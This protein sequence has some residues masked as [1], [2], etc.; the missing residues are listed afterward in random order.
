M[1]HRL[2]LFDIDETMIKSDGTGRRAM[3]RA[4]RQVFGIA[5][6]TTSVA[7]SGKTDWQICREILQE[8]GLISGDLEFGLN[9]VFQVYPPMLAEE[10]RRSAGYRLH[11]GVKELIAALLSTRSAYLGLVTGNI[12]PGARLKLAPFDLN[13]FFPVGAFGSDSADRMDLPP[14]A[15]NRAAAHYRTDFSPEEVVVVGDSIADVRCAAGYGALS[16]AVASGKTPRADLAACRPHFLF[17]SLQDTQAVLDA[18]FST[19]TL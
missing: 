19:R 18:I 7:M 14:I 6:D 13:R 2:V 17:E 16:I 3:V 15:R 10:I 9:Q 8:A 4:L 11:R 5:C 12:E 1:R